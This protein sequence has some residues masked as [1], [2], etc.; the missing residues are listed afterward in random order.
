MIGIIN[1]IVGSSVSFFGVLFY[2]YFVIFFLLIRVDPGDTIINKMRDA[3]IFTF[4]GG[5]EQDHFEARYIFFPMVIGTM[6]VTIILLNVLIAFMSN[7]YNKMEAQQVVVGLKERSSMLLDL[8]VYVSLFRKIGDLFKMKGKT[9]EQKE[10]YLNRN[11]KNVFMLNKIEGV[12]NKK[13]ANNALVKLKGLEK[14]I[15]GIHND[16]LNM[17]FHNQEEFT[18]IKKKIKGINKFIGFEQN[19]ISH[20]D[21]KMQGIFISMLED[22]SSGI[23]DNVLNT[24]EKDFDLKNKLDTNQENKNKKRFSFISFNR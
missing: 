5:V 8:E 20:F 14:E 17:N 24:L 6:I 22:F 2:T 23:T 16:L 21:A 19:D 10:E 4:F 12:V 11:Q 9:Q 1:T 18:D 3:Y 15:D 13:S 7:V